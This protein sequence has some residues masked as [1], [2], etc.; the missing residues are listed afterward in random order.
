VRIRPAGPSAAAGRRLPVAADP[1]LRPG[2]APPAGAPRRLAPARLEVERP[3]TRAARPAPARPPVEPPPTR[4]ARAE[5]EAGRRRG[6]RLAAPV[7]VRAVLR[8][9]AGP[10]VPVDRRAPRTGATRSRPARARP[11]PQAPQGG[12]LQRRLSPARGRRLL[13]ERRAVRRRALDAAQASPPG[14]PHAHSDPAI[15]PPGRRL[16]GEPAAQTSGR[17]PALARLV[18]PVLG[19]PRALGA[20]AR[21]GP[22]RGSGSTRR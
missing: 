22:A 5:A 20:P 7:R 12:E 4:A 17:H 9:G 2:E 10:A 16:R 8:V 11:D 6:A 19:R 13:Q 21:A 1:A 15:R 14:H 3:P 18:A